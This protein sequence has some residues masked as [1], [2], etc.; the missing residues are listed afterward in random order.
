MTSLRSPTPDKA[1]EIDSPNGI[2][3]QRFCESSGAV[4]GG[5]L[6]GFGAGI[7]HD[8][9]RFRNLWAALVTSCLPGAG[10]DLTRRLL[11]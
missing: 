10:V 1:L 3:E 4:D 6:S 7:R 8:P 2:V 5:P 9:Q 11:A